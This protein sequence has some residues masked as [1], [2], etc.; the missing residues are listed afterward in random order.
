MLGHSSISETPISAAPS[1]LIATITAAI[2]RT[3]VAL[4]TRI[5]ARQVQGR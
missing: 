5:G 2:R 3:L 1:T 4:G